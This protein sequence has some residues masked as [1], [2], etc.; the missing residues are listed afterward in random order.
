MLPPTTPLT[1]QLTA[2]FD[3]PV[4]V[5]VNCVVFP[6]NKLELEDETETATDWGGGVLGDEPPPQA[7]RAAETATRQI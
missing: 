4:T 2:V 3:V 6:S 5:A 7:V 1:L